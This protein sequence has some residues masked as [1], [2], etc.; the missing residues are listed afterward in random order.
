MVDPFARPSPKEPVITIAR[1]RPSKK[2]RPASAAVR[3]SPGRLHQGETQKRIELTI[4][5]TACVGDRG[6]SGHPESL[7]DGDTVEIEV[8]GVGRL[9]HYVE[10]S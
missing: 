7:S 6:T 4:Q 3:L 8:D 1:G 9:E 2:E 10:R 5:A